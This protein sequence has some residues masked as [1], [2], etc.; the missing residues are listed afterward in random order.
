MDKS[1]V[2]CISYVKRGTFMDV[3][4]VRTAVQFVI[5]LLDL[6]PYSVKL[7]RAA[8]A[9]ELKNPFYTRLG[10]FMMS[11]QVGPSRSIGR[12]R[13][14]CMSWLRKQLSEATIS[15]TIAAY[16]YRFKTTREKFCSFIDSGCPSSLLFGINFFC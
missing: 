9:G 15:V 1:L 13:L 3:L 5:A 12:K 2:S 16:V 11:F 8:V 10:S 4:V 14:F 6:S 7:L